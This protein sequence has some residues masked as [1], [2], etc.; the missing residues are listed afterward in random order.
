MGAYVYDLE[1]DEEYYAGS[2]QGDYSN[3]KR[4]LSDCQVLAYDFAEEKGFDK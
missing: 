1:R 3:R 2:V 4:V